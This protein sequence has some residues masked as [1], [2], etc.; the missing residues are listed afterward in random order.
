MPRR[1][2]LLVVSDR[3]DIARL[4]HA[5]LHLGQEDLTPSDAHRIVAEETVIGY[6]THNEDQFVAAIGEPVD[7]IA[8]G[9]VFGTSSKQNPDPV[10]GVEELRRLR[11][12]TG[13]PLVAIGGI[14]RAN[15]L[16][17]VAAGADS[18]AVIG[19]LFPESG[20]VRGRVKEWVARLS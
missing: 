5:G 3:A 4:I 20:D 16:S 12:M 10:V 9:P 8:F 1:R 6:S 11:P 15:V 13:L 17:V 18:V 7:Y 19:D 2:A 14:T